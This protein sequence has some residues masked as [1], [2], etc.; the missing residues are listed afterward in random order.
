MPKDRP[1]K[2]PGGIHGGVSL[3]LIPCSHRCAHQSEGYCTLQSLSHATSGAG[4]DCIYFQ[5]RSPKQ[6]PELPHRTDSGQ[7]EAGVIFKADRLDI[8]RGQNH[9]PKS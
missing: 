2:R 3:Y 9:L 7:L 6:T 4:G 8:V 5:E 1:A